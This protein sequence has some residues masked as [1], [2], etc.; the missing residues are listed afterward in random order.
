MGDLLIKKSRDCFGGTSYF[1]YLNGQQ[2]TEGYYSKSELI[3]DYPEFK[4]AKVK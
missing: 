1:G 4:K 2:Y 3:E